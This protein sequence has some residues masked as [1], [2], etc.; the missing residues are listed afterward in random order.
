MRPALLL[1]LAAVVAVPAIGCKAST[2]HTGK[3][4]ITARSEDEAR[5]AKP[6]EVRLAEREARLAEASQGSA[7]TV[8]PSEQL[9]GVGSTHRFH[10]SNC[11]ALE[12]V[13]RADRVLFVSPYDALDGGYAP[14]PVCK[15]RP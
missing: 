4:P 3:R 5:E 2:K 1:V 15:P 7:H 12:S 9:V 14:C 11:A 6:I 10:F 13:P 8:A